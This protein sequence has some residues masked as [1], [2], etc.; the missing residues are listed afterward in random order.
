MS[1]DLDPR[2][3]VVGD[4]CAGYRVVNLRY[5][6]ARAVM[7][8]QTAHDAGVQLPGLGRG[9]IVV[10]TESWSFFV[11]GLHKKKIPF[12]TDTDPTFYLGIYLLFIGPRYSDFWADWHV[13]LHHFDRHLAMAT[14]ILRSPRSPGHTFLQGE[15]IETLL[16][17][18]T[19]P[20]DET[21]DAATSCVALSRATCLK[22]LYLVEAITL[23][24]LRHKPEEDV[25]A[26]L[27]WLDR[28]D[29]ATQKMF[30]ED[31]S[32]FRPITVSSP[33]KGTALDTNGDDA[34]DDDIR[35]GSADRPPACTWRTMLAQIAFTTLRLLCYWQLLTTYPYLLVHLARLL[36][37]CSTPPWGPFATQCTKAVFF[38]PPFW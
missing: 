13:S 36:L 5:P 18:M 11:E 27:E 23:N 3:V 12:S 21:V 24:D 37:P 30:L 31:A 14:Y 17:H 7:F 8:L 15:T 10:G 26:T 33:H 29:S 2:E 19:K 38:P 32:T 25:A 9:D 20:T 34:S 1:V 35:S 28:L 16:L 6:P 4:D 22:K